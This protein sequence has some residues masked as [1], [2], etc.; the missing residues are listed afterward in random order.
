MISKFKKKAKPLSHFIWLILLI[1]ITSFVTYFYDSNKKSQHEIFKKT[2][3]NVYFKKTL[4]KITSVLEDRYTIIEH[5]VKSGDNYES[6]I[7]LFKLSKK[8]KK[9]FLS[10]IKKNKNIKIL[11][12]NQ[13]I[14]FKVDNKGEPKIIEFK[15]E[16]SKKKRNLFY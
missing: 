13:K 1:T 6:I 14:Y 4:T 8:E 3:S 7:N 11:R 15:I 5:V 9:I 10:T 12:P 2:L 16:V